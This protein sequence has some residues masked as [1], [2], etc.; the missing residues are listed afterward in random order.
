MRINQSGQVATEYIVILSALAVSLSGL[1]YFITDRN[2]HSLYQQS[3]Q[4]MRDYIET[5]HFILSLPY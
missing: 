5:I 2:G 1:I 3:L 4:F